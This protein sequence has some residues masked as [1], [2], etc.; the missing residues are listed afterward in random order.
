MEEK[1]S[2]ELLSLARKAENLPDDPEAL[3]V[4]FVEWMKL[5]DNFPVFGVLSRFGR[6][7]DQKRPRTKILSK[8]SIFLPEPFL[9][10]RKSLLLTHRL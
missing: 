2:E 4:V 6:R 9:L 5:C 7:F 8:R 10:S 1:I 3:A